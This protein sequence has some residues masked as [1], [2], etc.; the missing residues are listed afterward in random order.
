MRY[1]NCVSRRSR[2][3]PDYG[4]GNR[5]NRLQL[6]EKLGTLKSEFAFAGSTTR[7]PISW[8]ATHSRLEEP[9]FGRRIKAVSTK[10]NG[11]LGDETL[12]L[13]IHRRVPDMTSRLATL[14]RR[15]PTPYTGRICRFRTAVWHRQQLC[16]LAVRALTRRFMIGLCIPVQ[17]TMVPRV[18][19]TNSTLIQLHNQSPYNRTNN[20]TRYHIQNGSSWSARIWWLAGDWQ[21]C[22]LH[23]ATSVNTEH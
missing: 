21:L 15:V 20:V 2:D 12:V 19:S 11:W 10:I 8:P 14:C 5:T 16:F 3:H 23:S 13:G 1:N 17:M 18:L 6:R 9:V 4:D 7:D 22:P